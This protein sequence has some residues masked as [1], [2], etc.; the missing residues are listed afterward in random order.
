MIKVAFVA[1]VSYSDE[2]RWLVASIGKQRRV[3]SFLSGSWSE[4]ISF[5]VQSLQSDRLIIKLKSKR[6]VSSITVAQYELSLASYNLDTTQIVETILERRPV[7]ANTSTNIPGILV[8][9]EYSALP[10]VRL[11]APEPTWTRSDV[12]GGVLLVVVHSAEGLTGSEHDCNPYCMIFNN[13]KKVRTTHYL[14]GTRNPQWESRTQILVSDVSSVA[15]SF[16]VCSWNTSKVADTDL[17]GLAVFSL[18]QVRMIRWRI[19]KFPTLNFPVLIFHL[20]LPNRAALKQISG[21][22]IIKNEGRVIQAS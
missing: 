14:R 9:L 12:Q 18:N 3:T 19:V 4:S 21:P 1:G 8:R 22:K 6:L 5:L 2:S 13:R 7:R 16:V 15:L 11:D 10:P 17:L 20:T